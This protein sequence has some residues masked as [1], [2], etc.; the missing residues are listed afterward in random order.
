MTLSQAGK[1]F[2]HVINT[3]A[4]E[5]MTQDYIIAIVEAINISTTMTHGLMSLAIE[6]KGKTGLEQ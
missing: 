5:L 4:W 6:S 1:A 2:F 3:T